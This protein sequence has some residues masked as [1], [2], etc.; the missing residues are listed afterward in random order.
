MDG[1]VISVGIID[2]LTTYVA[3]RGRPD[4][5]YE[6]R[7][8]GTTLDSDADSCPHCGPTEVKKFELR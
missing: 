3:D 4:A 6:C 2:R 5:V 7:T 1:I 8:C